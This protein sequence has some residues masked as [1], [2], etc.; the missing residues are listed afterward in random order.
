MYN[1]CLNPICA[2]L[3]LDTGRLRLACGGQVVER[4]VRPAMGEIVRAARANG[5]ELGEEVVQGMIES[6]PLE[7]Y[8]RPSMAADVRKVSSF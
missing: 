1:A 3:G 6:D 4:V 2:I 8:L 7:K 5:V